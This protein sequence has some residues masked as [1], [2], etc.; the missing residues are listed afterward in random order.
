MSEVCEPEELECAP[1]SLLSICIA[2]AGIALLLFYAGRSRHRSNVGM[3]PLIAIG[4]VDAASYT[5]CVRLEGV[6]YTLWLILIVIA[7]FVAYLRFKSRR[8]IISMMPIVIPSVMAYQDQTTSNASSLLWILIPSLNI[9][10]YISFLIEHIGLLSIKHYQRKID[11][12]VP[13]SLQNSYEQYWFSRFDSGWLEDSNINKHHYIFLLKWRCINRAKRLF[14]ADSIAKLLV[15]GVSSLDKF[16]V[17]RVLYVCAAR[18]EF[19]MADQYNNAR[20]RSGKR[21]YM[22]VTPNCQALNLAVCSLKPT[23]CVL[24]SFISSEEVKFLTKRF[25]SVAFHVAP[26]QASSNL[27]TNRDFYKHISLCFAYAFELLDCLA[28]VSNIELCYIRVRRDNCSQSY[29]CVH[30]STSRQQGYTVLNSCQST[31]C[32]HKTPTGFKTLLR[33]SNSFDDPWDCLQ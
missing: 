13:I 8:L 1:L 6:E 14:K 18:N 21:I 19:F 27:D 31:G 25:P 16:Q 20:F 22:N 3:I 4:S 24:T 10:L 7:A 29:V 2:T 15:H 12:V 26:D 33:I 9:V 17:A 28:G 23:D 32:H 5:T 30:R 11:K